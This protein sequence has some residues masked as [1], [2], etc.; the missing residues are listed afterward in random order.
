MLKPKIR[1]IVE[2]PFTKEE[3]LQLMERLGLKEPRDLLRPTDP[4]IEYLNLSDPSLPDD[5]ILAA[6]IEYPRYPQNQ[7]NNE[8]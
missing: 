7:K 4:F 6:M 2:T 5:D 8:K 3:I 1:D